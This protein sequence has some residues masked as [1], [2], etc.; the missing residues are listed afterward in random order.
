MKITERSVYLVLK[1][2]NDI[3]AI[4]RCSI[5]P[6]W[7]AAPTQVTCRIARSV[8]DAQRV[9]YVQLPSPETSQRY[10]V[11]E[12]PSCNARGTSAVLVSRPAQYPRKPRQIP[13]SATSPAKMPRPL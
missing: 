7:P 6:L 4:L 10:P 5:C 8:S 1:L 2:N 3:R 12:C 13:R 11:R 9:R